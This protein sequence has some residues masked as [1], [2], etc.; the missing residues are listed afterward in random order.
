VDTR[1]VLGQVYRPR[2]IDNALDD[3][4]QTAGAVLVEGARATGKT[5]TALNAAQSFDFLDDPAVAN[6][7][8]ISPA[9]VLEGARPR[10]LDEWQVAP[11]VWNLVRRAVDR[12]PQLGQFVL[13]GSA[14]P[15]DDLTRH[16][17][18]GRF[19][20]LRQRTM[21]W[22]EKSDSH[23]RSV[24]LGELFDG[25][26]PETSRSAIDLTEV[27]DHLSQPG[28]PA[29]TGLEVRRSQ[30]RLRAY[31][32][33]IALSDVPRLAQIRHDQT[34]IRQLLAAIARS[35]A[36]GVRFTTL[37]DDVS[38]VAPNITAQT[39][40]DYVSLLERLFIVEYQKPWT[41]RL[42][43]RA[44]LRT[45]AKIHLADPALALAASGTSV[46][47]LTREPSWLG[48]LFESAAVHDLTVFASNLGG[49]VRHYL[50]SNGQEI[51]A[52]VTLPDGR[53]GAVEIK[54]GAPQIE[55]AIV[56]L[57]KS[58]SEIDTS[59]VGEPA[60]RLV[61]TG[62]GSVFT[63]KDGTITAPLIALAP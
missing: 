43:S 49:E 35:V 6:L 8:Q 20:R 11:E 50:N 52:I 3:A 32:D 51:D 53:W 19:L 62:T 58:V 39:I 16:T 57:N 63:A 18:A 4:L 14:V 40:G 55:S 23:H 7:L 46:S 37:A 48:Q 28:F 5:M 10:L 47:Q 42:R 36:T 22:F 59:V 38:S 45:S 44:R 24:S 13:T 61:L 31:L 12:S 1:E 17:G 15:V 29:M 2:V 54:L 26:T 56:S 41:P 30:V 25:A 60:F 21:T 33:E 9:T 34:V 27:I